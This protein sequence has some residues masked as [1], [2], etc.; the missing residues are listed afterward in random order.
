MAFH[1]PALDFPGVE[2]E[3]I[4]MDLLLTGKARVFALVTCTLL[5]CGCQ[6]GVN[7]SVAPSAISSVSAST[8]SNSAVVIPDDVITTQGAPVSY[9]MNEG[10]VASGSYSGY[11]GTCT[12]AST[13]TGG[14]RVR[15]DGQGVANELIQF[16]VVDVTPDPLH[17]DSHP[18]TTDYVDVNQQGA[19]R[20]GWSPIEPGVFI[21]GHDLQCQLTQNSNILASSS[22]IF[23]AP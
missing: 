9:S 23:P 1:T 13:H 20:T 4:A 18:R 10:I 8:G 6:S 17:P 22:S 12:V 5:T 7:N 19:F 2:E 16:N 15:A 14:L 11:S 3:S 21:A